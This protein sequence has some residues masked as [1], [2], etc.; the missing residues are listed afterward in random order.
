MKAERQARGTSCCCDFPPACDGSGI[1][2]C[3]G[4]GGDQC[5][6]SRCGG[7]GEA[8]CEGCLFCERTGEYEIPEGT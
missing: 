1:I 5:V 6:C 3:E 8:E 2:H 4:C 7:A